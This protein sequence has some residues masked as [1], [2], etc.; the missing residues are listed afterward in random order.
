MFRRN[1]FQELRH[2]IQEAIASII[3]DT[4]TKVQEELNFGWRSTT[5]NAYIEQLKEKIWLL[6]FQFDA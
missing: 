6:Y 5:I 1:Y 2:I 3:H 4:L